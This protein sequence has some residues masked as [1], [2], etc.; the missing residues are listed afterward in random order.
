MQR[1]VATNRKGPDA[2]PSRSAFVLALL[3]LKKLFDGVAD[4]VER[5]ADP[6]AQG[7]CAANDCDR[8]QRGDQSIFDSGCPGLVFHKPLHKR[9]HSQDLSDWCPVVHQNIGTLN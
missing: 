3:K 1:A 6:N 8:D 2:D 4:V 9:P 5:G 7:A